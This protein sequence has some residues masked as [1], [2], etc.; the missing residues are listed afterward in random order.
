MR[1]FAN[2]FLVYIGT[3]KNYKLVCR[4][5][6][7]KIKNLKQNFLRFYSSFKTTECHK[8]SLKKYTM[9]SY[10]ISNFYAIVSYNFGIFVLDFIDRRYLHPPVYLP[11]RQILLPAQIVTLNITSREISYLYCRLSKPNHCRIFFLQEG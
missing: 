10:N 7:F 4:Q 8:L 1:S 6:R 3:I 5:A 9:T 2:I 11:G